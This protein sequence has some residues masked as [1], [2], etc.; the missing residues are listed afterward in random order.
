MTEVKVDIK[1]TYDGKGA[2]EAKTDLGDVGKKG[3]ADAAGL[4]SSFGGLGD[5]LSGGIGDLAKGFGLALGAKEIADFAI[6]TF[7]LAEQNRV[8]TSSFTNL[9]GSA[10]I[11]K[12]NLQA[13]GRATRGLISE[14]EQMQIA[15]QLLG[16]QIVQTDEQLE[17]VVGVSRR[18]GKEFRGIGAREAADE[19]ALMIA[20]MSKERLDTFGISSGNVT[21]RMAELKA[22]T[23]GMT[24]E[25]IFFQATMEEA[26]KT[27]QRLGPEINTT[28]DEVSRLGA[29]F[30]NL[31][32]ALGAVAEES[33][34]IGKLIKTAADDLVR[35]TALFDDTPEAQ[36]KSLNIQL[37]EAQERLAILAEREKTGGFFGIIAAAQIPSATEDVAELTAEFARLTNAQEF[38]AQAGRN[39]QEALQA[40]I[41]SEEKV[42]ENVAKRAEAVKRLAE[43][44]QEFSRDVI[45]LQRET[46]DQI[47]DSQEK[48]DDDSEKNEADH[49]K[50]ISDM[51]Q[52]ADEGKIKAGKKL[53]KDLSKI[54]DSLKKNLAKQQIDEDKAVVKAQQAADKDSKISRRQKQ[55]DAAGDERLFQ[56]ELR[57]L[58]ADGNGIAIQEALERRAIEEEIASEKAE[59]EKE[60]ERDKKDDQIASIREEG[61]ER[62]AQ[63]QQQARGRADDLKARN[64]EEIEARK[65]R[66]EAEILQEGEGFSTRKT[67]LETFFDERNAEIREGEQEGLSEI[68]KALTQAE[69]LTNTQLDSMVTLAKEF[70]PKFGEAFADGMTKA[71]SENLKIKGAIA[72]ASDIGAGAGPLPLAEGGETTGGRNGITRFANGGFVERSGIAFV[73]KGEQVIPADQASGGGLTINIMAP[74]FGVDDLDAKLN[75]WGQGIIDA[76]AGAMN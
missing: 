8:V 53:Q 35:F 63:L 3:K 70:G 76:T 37:T 22:T 31:Q 15:N 20:N 73:D 16:M 45:G 69:D 42:A 4:K 34:V 74:V 5:V 33:G 43:V 60:T 49:I 67:N 50:R 2:K 7:K 59:F 51:R 36:L 32:V 26:E 65:E 21:E 1:T 28:S 52:Q 47:L 11:A 30:S 13:M 38:A 12:I 17:Q 18:L 61:A 55:I 29:A 57:R 10:N 24:K 46:S 62:R 44:Q 25:Q 48:F 72:S 19:F 54:D 6:E 75:V 14:T 58:A 23:E 39:E 68:A 40:A 56:F 71:I 27:M 64:T 41:A 66:L 9:S